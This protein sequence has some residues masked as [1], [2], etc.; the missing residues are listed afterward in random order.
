MEIP[1]SGLLTPTMESAA[2]PVAFLG[3]YQEAARA[4]G[5]FAFDDVVLAAIKEHG[6]P[7][8]RVRIR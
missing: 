3:T 2:D 5:W 1:S 7:Q 4:K 6:A 8:G